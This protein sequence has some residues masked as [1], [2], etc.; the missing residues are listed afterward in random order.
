M[1]SRTQAATSKL[2]R[3]SCIVAQVAESMLEKDEVLP[4][5]T[6]KAAEELILAAM[7][8]MEKSP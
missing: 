1:D 2:H 8:L 6:L 5:E 3:A 4:G 7:E